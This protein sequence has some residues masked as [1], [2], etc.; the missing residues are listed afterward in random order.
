MYIQL[1]ISETLN[2][3]ITGKQRRILCVYE[4]KRFAKLHN[5]ILMNDSVTLYDL[6]SAY[7]NNI[8]KVI[9][10]N[11]KYIVNL[12]VQESIKYGANLYE[13][14]VEENINDNDEEN[15][16]PMNVIVPTEEI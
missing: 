1:Q 4:E 8:R 3:F 15:K 2:S 14:R 12:Q 5:H 11:R 7:S 6:M 9:N 10:R 13:F 16:K